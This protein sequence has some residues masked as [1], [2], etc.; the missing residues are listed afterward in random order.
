LLTAQLPDVAL[1]EIL[2]GATPQDV[3]IKNQLVDLRNA[4]SII[5]RGAT[6]ADVVTV[7]RVVRGPTGAVVGAVEVL[8]PQYRAKIEDVMPL[9]DE[10]VAALS[11]QLGSPRSGLAAEVTKEVI[12]SEELAMGVLSPGIQAI[13][14]QK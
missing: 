11:N 9:I 10:A 14:L 3:A 4:G 5:D 8:I 1:E 6:E 2:S 12:G 7:A 13:G